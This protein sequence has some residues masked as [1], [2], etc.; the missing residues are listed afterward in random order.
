MKQNDGTLVLQALFSKVSLLCPTHEPRQFKTTNKKIPRRK[1]SLT[2]FVLVI[3]LNNMINE[4]TTPLLTRIVSTPRAPNVKR[5][6]PKL[7]YSYVFGILFLLVTLIVTI[8]GTLP[9][10][11]SDAQ[12]LE[13]NDFPGIHCY[14]E[15]L[16]RFNTPH[17]ANQKDNG[18][19]KD[20]IVQL[21]RDFK[22][23]ATQNGVTMEIIEDDP[24]DLVSKRDKFS[25]GKRNISVLK[26]VYTEKKHYVDEYWLV[27]S[28]N[29]IIRLVGRSNN[30]NE[31][32]LINA[33]YGKLN[34]YLRTENADMYLRQ[35]IYEPWR[36]R[37]WYGYCSSS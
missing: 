21:A 2:V 1:L 37:Q 27:E 24:T 29:V 14:N 7:I 23:E 26:A 10:P 9:T 11:L 30:T 16:S 20:W 35:C 4:E 6:T 25:T 17:S 8:R 33:H 3:L 36:D 12:A 31:S 22:V 18:I 34:L 32:F 19:L 13:L 15:Y 28:R 5:N